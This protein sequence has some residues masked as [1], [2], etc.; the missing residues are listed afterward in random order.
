[1]KAP[2]YIFDGSKPKG[3]VLVLSLVVM[4]LVFAAASGLYLNRQMWAFSSTK[5]LD[6]AIMA[7]SARADA[8]NWVIQFRDAWQS[9]LTLNLATSPIALSGGST[10]GL[11]GG[12]G[13]FTAALPYPQYP[14]SVGTLG[15][16]FKFNTSM[17]IVPQVYVT[18]EPYW[19]LDSYLGAVDV[20]FRRE[21]NDD[22]FIVRR[23]RFTPP[24]APGPDS[25][26]SGS[27]L[28]AWYSLDGALPVSMV[29][30][31]VP[32]SAFTLFVGAPM[33]GVSSDVPV[34]SAWLKSGGVGYDHGGYVVSD[35][36]VGR[37][38]VEGVMNAGSL[39]TSG[40]PIGST[41][42]FSLTGGG[43]FELLFP[44]A[45]GG[46][47]QS[48]SWT[49]E[50]EFRNN[51]Y[52]IYRGMMV[53]SS[54]A[55]SRL[56]RH[57][58]AKSGGKWVPIPLGTA[59]PNVPGYADR[60]GAF[61]AVSITAN[62]VNHVLSATRD[63]ARFTGNMANFTA[64]SSSGGAWTWDVPNS[65][66]IFSPPSSSWLNGFGNLD[67][68]KVTFRNGNGTLNT[69]YK[70]RVVCPNPGRPFTLVVP[71]NPLVLE[72][73]FNYAGTQASML[74]APDVY[75]DDTPTSSGPYVIKGVLLT[76][77]ASA[78]LPVYY[79][80]SGTVPLVSLEGSLVV[81]RKTNRVSGALAGF[82]VTPSLSYLQ[83]TVVPPICPAAV[84][85]R[86]SSPGFKIYDVGAYEN[87]N[88]P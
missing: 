35:V 59:D 73:G 25:S 37:L 47:S 72:A 36:G 56:L 39:I 5:Q 8:Q 21:M 78:D 65:Q 23:D 11:I 28:R 77:A 46:G 88:L 84:D 42:G 10:V 18:G 44:S 41:S 82:Q 81:W 16:P 86:A 30:R 53:T 31:V 43:S 14:V 64:L 51:R 76:E 49:T 26:R 87:A 67:S 74:V 4:T 69:S 13:G 22:D 1:M 2:S 83:G 62:V 60:V 48:A 29:F 57:G 45:S 19:G 55:P 70:L 71:S 63:P 7:V 3:F 58:V 12:G 38:Y 6:Q 20:L 61:S 33:A 27:H 66:L 54:D 68:L 75:V 52:S 34:S 32:L 17:D 15:L 79:A 50:Q 24:S 40:F 85:V 80:G 9:N